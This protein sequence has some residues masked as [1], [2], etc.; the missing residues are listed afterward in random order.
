MIKA[1]FW[2]SNRYYLLLNSL[3][4]ALL[5]IF[6]FLMSKS[7][8]FKFPVSF[9]ILLFI[10]IFNSY[11]FGRYSVNFQKADFYSFKSFIA[12]ISSY[13]IGIFSYFLIDWVTSSFIFDS[14]YKMSLIIYSLIFIFISDLI[15]IGLKLVFYRKN[16]LNANWIFVDDNQSQMKNYK[17][18]IRH[19]RK[20]KIDIIKPENLGIIK[21]HKYEGLVIY[22]TDN[23]SEDLLKQLKLI[24]SSGIVVISLF[25]F[26][27]RYFER[28]PPNLITNK[29]IISRDFFIPRNSSIL[30]L[31]RLGDIFLASFLIFLTI[32]IILT[33][34]IL[35]KL[36]DGGPIFYSQ[37]RNGILN[38]PFNIW[39]LRTMK[40]NSEKHGA[41]WSSKKDPRIT[42]IGKFLRKTRLDELP[43]LICVVRGE[44]SLIGPRPE[45]P[46]FDKDLE[47]KINHYSVRKWIR[48]GL[49][50]W[51]QVNYPYTSSIKDSEIKV[52]YD[53]YYL[54]N[55]SFWLDILILFKTIKMLIHVKGSVP[56]SN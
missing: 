41:K 12:T 33:A 17:N 52:S 50:G 3:S 43:Q 37:K 4:D 35:I 31:K 18:L 23:L 36:E 46:E 53:L 24:K 40:V 10:W 44:M 49:S 2:F 22:S 5:F 11:I 1:N 28:I 54:R 6:L 51:A 19:N 48:P 38:I 30:R 26:Y 55:F 56:K 45:R 21:L 9:I 39:K 29:D 13:S 8:T 16:K 32:P 25:L 47:K 34:S 7:F 27:E 20:I 15:L 42:S 14:E